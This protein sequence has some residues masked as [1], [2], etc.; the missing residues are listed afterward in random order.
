MFRLAKFPSAALVYTP[1]RSALNVCRWHTAPSIDVAT[2]TP[3]S[4]ALHMK[5]Y[6]ARNIEVIILDYTRASNYIPSAHNSL[7]LFDDCLACEYSQYSES[8]AQ[9]R[10]NDCQ[11]HFSI[12]HQA[13]CLQCKGG[14]CSKASAYP[15][16]QE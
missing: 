7:S 15:N 5:I 1:F 11:M 9:Y 8:N 16:L 13:C 14:K 2:V 6:P 3:H 4:S 12:F 10:I